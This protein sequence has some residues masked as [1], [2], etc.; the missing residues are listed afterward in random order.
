[1]PVTVYFEH[2]RVVRLEPEPN[3][4]YYEV[5]DTINA[6]TD[7][8]SDGIKYDLNNRQSIY[9]IAIPDYTK[10]RD[11]PHSKV[12]GVTGHLE[13]VLRMHAGRLW[14]A[15]DYQLSMAC[16]E[17]SCQLMTY[18]T[19]GWER[20]DFYRVVNYYI[21][22]GRFKKAKEWKDWIDAHTEAPEDYAD[23]AFSRTLESCRFLETDLVEVGDLSACCGTCAKYRKRIYS[24]SGKSWK[25]PKFPT[26]FHFQC[27]LGISPYVEGVSEP[28]FKCISPVLY[29]RRPFRDDRT[30]EEKTNYKLRLEY[31][32]KVCN[33]INAPNLSHIIYYWF[34]PKFPNDFPKSL[35]GFSHMRNANT[36]NYQKLVKKIEDAGY[37]IPKSL[38]EVAEW[39]EREN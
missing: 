26:D 34:K 35:S 25:F 2:G 11:V 5:R 18:S 14:N 12:L 19:I 3:Q 24:L 32:K 39:D 31:I 22:L 9:S 36:A 37:T 8:V 13:Y 1:M 29:S 38:D 33:P 27:A 4:S 20:K 21:E 7:I 6:A 16:L 30:D 10:V 23:D 28:T 17:K 15:G